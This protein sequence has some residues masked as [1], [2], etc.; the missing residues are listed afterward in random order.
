VAADEFF[1]NA[2]HVGGVSVL[3]S[4]PLE[5]AG[6]NDAEII[7]AGG[8]GMG[9]KEGFKRLERFAA[10]VGAGVGAS[11]SAVD[12]GYA[13]YDRQIGQTGVTVSP[14]TYVAW[15][16]SGAAQHVAG[17]RRAGVVVA[18]NTDPRAP[19]FL[20]SDIAIVASWEDVLSEA[21]RLLAKEALR[22]DERPP[23]CATLTRPTSRI[24][25]N[26][27]STGQPGRKVR[28]CR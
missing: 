17:I 12:A 10:G 1:V 7:L 28:P 13:P 2:G 4:S 22:F 15:A 16:I 21:E 5:G 11:R 9:G 19:M 27:N 26:V 3:A 23:D 24:A 8:K 20:Y 18:V 6:L 14:A 25:Q